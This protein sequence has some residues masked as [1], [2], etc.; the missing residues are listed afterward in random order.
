MYTLILVSVTN[1]RRLISEPRT[2]TP[3]VKPSVEAT[4]L[5]V[6]IDKAREHYYYLFNT[7]G[8]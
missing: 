5:L 3:V 7:S 4:G 8:A 1:G 6:C 2:E